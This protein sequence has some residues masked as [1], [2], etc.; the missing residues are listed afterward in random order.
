MSNKKTKNKICEKGTKYKCI[1]A[2]NYCKNGV[3]RSTFSQIGLWDIDPT[4][5]MDALAHLYSNDH[6]WLTESDGKTY[7]CI[8]HPLKYNQGLDK[9]IEKQTIIDLIVDTQMGAKMNEKF[10]E[11]GK[12]YGN[13]LRSITQDTK[14]SL[15]RLPNDIEG[16]FN[17]L[18]ITPY[19]KNE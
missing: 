17:S 14:A 16:M 18:K 11:L 10:T 13:R 6:T 4:Y 15:D 3:E 1:H 19:Q 12:I 9:K 5:L 8:C 2:E 7:L